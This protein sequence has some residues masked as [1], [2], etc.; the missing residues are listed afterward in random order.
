M[1]L[2]LDMETYSPCQRK[3]GFVLENKTK[4][5]YSNQ[6]TPHPMY[7]YT[8]TYICT[9]IYPSIHMCSNKLIIVPI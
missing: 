3:H 4:S 9:H 8:H 2:E 6:A 1:D 5:L 7:M